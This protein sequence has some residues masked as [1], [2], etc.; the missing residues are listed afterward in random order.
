MIDVNDYEYIFEP[1]EIVASH[2]V[3]QGEPR[4]L[5]KD[6]D[7]MNAQID[8]CIWCKRYMCDAV[9]RETIIEPGEA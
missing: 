2:V 3:C 1:G 4:C 9:G 7:A 8:G 6:D 5:L